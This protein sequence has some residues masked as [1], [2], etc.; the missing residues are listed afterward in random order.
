MVGMGELSITSR[1]MM[2]TLV[3][4]LP[5][6]FCEMENVGETGDGVVDGVVVSERRLDRLSRVRLFEGRDGRELRL[7]T[8]F[9]MLLGRRACGWCS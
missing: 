9:I 1:L 7:R 6:E 2:G 8:V 5:F 3:G 4:T